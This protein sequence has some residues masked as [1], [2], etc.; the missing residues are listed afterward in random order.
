M[1]KT[2]AAPGASSARLNYVAI[3]G[4]NPDVVLAELTFAPV[5]GYD[6]EKLEDDLDLQI[7]SAFDLEG[8]AFTWPELP[9]TP[10]LNISIFLPLVM[11]DQA[12]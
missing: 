8:E 5:G 6:M 7:N 4:I 12:P 10:T 9:P 3:N 11:R 2:A 1:K